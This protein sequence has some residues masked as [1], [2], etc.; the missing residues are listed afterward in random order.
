MFS[1]EVSSFSDIASALHGVSVSVNQSLSPPSR[2]TGRFGGS[3]AGAVL[4]LFGAFEQRV[5]LDF[6]V[7]EM[8]EF[9]M[10]ELQ[11]TDRLQQL[12]RHHQRLRLTQLQFGCK[13]HFYPESPNPTT[14]RGPLRAKFCAGIQTGPAFACQGRL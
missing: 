2:T 3:S 5:A 9:D 12:R 7:D 11:Q 13:R 8:L 1:S 6:L 14:L 10:G 4:A